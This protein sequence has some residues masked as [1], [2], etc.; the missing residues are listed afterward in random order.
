MSIKS[1]GASANNKRRQSMIVKRRND[2]ANLFIFNNRNIK[3]KKRSNNISNKTT[4]GKVKQ[5]KVNRSS[6]RQ[7]NVQPFY[8]DFI[9][10]V[11]A[12]VILIGLVISNFN[13]DKLLTVNNRTA[14]YLK[15]TEEAPGRTTTI[16][17]SQNNP[18]FSTYPIWSQNF[19]SDYGRL[20]NSKYWNINI[21]APNNG[22]NEAEY[23]T[24][25]PSNL[26]ISNGALILEATHQQEPNGYQYG[27]G[28]VDTKNK[29]SFLYGRIDVTAKLPSG[30][31]TWPAIWMLPANKKYE[32]LGPA[33]NPYP[34]LN[35]GEIDIAEEV[36]FNPNTVYGIVHTITT[37]RNNPNAVG[38]FNQVDI[39]NNDSQ[40][41]TYSLLWT[42][43]SITFEINNNPYFVYSKT[44]GANY[45][46]WPFDQP[47]YLIID[48][49]LGGVWGGEDTSQFPGNGIDNTALP[50]KLSIQSIYYYSYT[51]FAASPQ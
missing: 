21:G 40:Y 8:F 31:G 9:R 18:Q 37:N 14:S 3:K 20:L 33:N 17:P 47:F 46:T 27:S 28:R 38:D 49:A 6:F 42:P 7:T 48:L 10:I 22:N 5:V 24:N 30:V 26:R 1:K 41:N 4:K 23:Y 36:G 16:G 34:F 19:S 12:L 39:P 35:G 11:L 29:V 25:Q 2:L 43:S 15:Q 44:S 32:L 50:A 45:T 13:L 51:G